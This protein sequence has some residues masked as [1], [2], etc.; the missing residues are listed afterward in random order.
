MEKIKKLKE[1]RKFLEE[2][3]DYW[4]N[5][6]RKD[7]DLKYYVPTDLI[8]EELEKYEIGI[9]KDIEQLM[10]ENHFD[11]FDYYMQLVEEKKAVYRGGDNT[12]NHCG[13]GQNDFQWHTFEIDNIY[14]VLLAFHIGGDIRANYTDY[15]VL[16]FEYETQFLEVVNDISYE[17]SL[18]FDLN[19]DGNIYEITP[20]VFS[21]C[22]EVYDRNNDIN[23]YQIYGINE[24]EVIEQIVEQVK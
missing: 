10:Q 5:I 23:I 11:E 8:C 2:K 18:T 14:I 7:L 15:I 9:N 4:W 19:V 20:F 13:R 16:E 17:Y 3:N 24:E 6:E 22:V 21:E 12:Y 1:I